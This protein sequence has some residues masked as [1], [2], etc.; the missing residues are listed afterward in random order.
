MTHLVDCD[1]LK[2]DENPISIMN[3]GKFLGLTI[4]DKLS[5]KE[6]SRVVSHKL[7]KTIGIFCELRHYLTEKQLINL[8]YSL[9]YPHLTYCNTIWGGCCTTFINDI[10]LL[11][12]KIIRIITQQ[13]YLAHTNPLFYQTGILKIH[14]IHDYL[15]AIEGYKAN[16][17][18]KFT[19]PSHSY[20]TRSSA[21]PI[22]NYQRLTSAQKSLS[23]SVPQMWNKLPEHVKTASSLVVFKKRCKEYLLS[24]YIA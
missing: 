12:K 22:S 11:Q 14:D 7:S 20:E 23:Y 8:Y 10:L 24:K 5:F 18:Q 4:D 21:Y 15:L 2:Y 16:I 3:K 1:S 6:H 19:Y 13:S 9:I 17:Q